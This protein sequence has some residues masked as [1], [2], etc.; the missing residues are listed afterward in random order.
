MKKLHE[1]Q[2]DEN[3]I[4]CSRSESGITF[5]LSAD[6]KFICGVIDIDGCVLKEEEIRKCDWLFL[7]NDKNVRPKPVA[8]FI[9]L[10]RGNIHEASEQI[11]NAIDR[12]KSQLANYE[13]E[14]RVVSAKG[15]QPEIK[16]S[17]YYKKV[18]KIIKKDI[19]FCPVHKG[20]KFTH[21]E[22]I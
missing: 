18:R 11:Y 20:N 8:Y 13:I 5:T 4:N 14:A 22:K 1:C 19:E 7:V 21:V 12:T 10:K 16:N 6:K 17:G 2:T 3:S 15:I 9:E